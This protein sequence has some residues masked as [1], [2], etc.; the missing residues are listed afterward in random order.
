MYVLKPQVL[1]Y[2]LTSFIFSV[3]SGGSSESPETSGGSRASISN[4]AHHGSDGSYVNT[5]SYGGGTDPYHLR[6]SA[7]RSVGNPSGT[8]LRLDAEESPRSTS[9]R[10]TVPASHGAR[11][12]VRA[13]RLGSPPE[14]PHH[15]PVI[16]TIKRPNGGPF[17]RP[18]R[19]PRWVSPPSYAALDV[20]KVLI[21]VHLFSLSD[22]FPGDL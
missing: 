12:S 13:Q 16:A 11:K 21:W 18:S 20:I 15:H 5:T 9:L 22:L 10:E 4:G 17:R 14:T 3:Y 8:P 2:L 19:L 1:R 7:E 6:S